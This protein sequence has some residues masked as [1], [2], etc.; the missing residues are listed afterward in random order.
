MSY[1]QRKANWAYGIQC[2]LSKQG[3]DISGSGAK[4]NKIMVKFL[5]EKNLPYRKWN[6]NYKGINTATLINSEPIQERFE[7]FKKWVLNGC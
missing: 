3:H 5:K 4:M 6:Y 7:E 2:F 1:I